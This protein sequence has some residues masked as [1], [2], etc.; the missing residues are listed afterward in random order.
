MLDKAIYW[1]MI[2]ANRHLADGHRVLLDRLF[3]KDCNFNCGAPV[4]HC[5]GMVEVEARFWQPLLQAF[6]DLERRTDILM[7]GHFKEGDWISST[8]YL[9]GHFVN[10]LWGIK[11]SGRPIP[12]LWLV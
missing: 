7:G 10:D 3:A 8:G 11:A 9:V 12:P 6:P 2:M 4:D 5:D 1:Q